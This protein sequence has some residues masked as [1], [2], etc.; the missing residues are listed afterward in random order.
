MIFLAF[1][2]VITEY[3]VLIY[4]PHPQIWNEF[5]SEI[6]VAKRQIMI[7]TLKDMAILYVTGKTLTHHTF[8][9]TF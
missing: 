3:G 5:I 4:L 2:N 8:V 7:Y 9:K 1:K 6:Y